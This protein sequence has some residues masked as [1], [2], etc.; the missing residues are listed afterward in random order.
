M[1]GLTTLACCSALL[2]VQIDTSDSA[3]VLELV[4]A[5]GHPPALQLGTSKHASAIFD[6]TE[7][8]ASSILSVLRGLSTQSVQVRG[9]SFC[10]LPYIA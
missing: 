3:Y 10:P 8:S 9:P 5:N 6:L 1:I 2:G 4:S 7:Q